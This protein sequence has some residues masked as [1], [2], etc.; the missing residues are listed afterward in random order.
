MSI[1]DGDK[2]FEVLEQVKTLSK[3][4]DELQ[5]EID[6]IKTKNFADK[7]VAGSSSNSSDSKFKS[8][9]KLKPNFFQRLTFFDKGNKT[10]E[11][12][13]HEVGNSIESSS[14]KDTWSKGPQIS[15]EENVNINDKKV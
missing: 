13:K 5:V 3:I 9:N 10:N 2:L 8:N 11:G 15:N 6:N 7:I 12:E 4:V 14:K 1:S